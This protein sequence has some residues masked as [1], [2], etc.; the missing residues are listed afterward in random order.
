MH[1]ERWQVGNNQWQV[2]YKLDWF[3]L[4]TAL[5]HFVPDMTMMVFLISSRGYHSNMLDWLLFG[6]IIDHHYGTTC[7]FLFS[8][9]L[10]YMDISFNFP[11]GQKAGRFFSIFST[12]QVTLSAC[13]TFTCSKWDGRWVKA[14]P[15]RSI[16]LHGPPTWGDV[17]WNGLFWIVRGRSL[18]TVRLWK[19]ALDYYP[20]SLFSSAII[21]TH[22]NIRNPHIY[23]AGAWTS[24]E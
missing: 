15:V 13:H 6:S 9:N 18:S 14:S 16:C 10:R 21:A 24:H 8:I 2:G 11:V 12:P 19:T 23:F 17:E 5:F 3:Q 4:L 22:S 1:G 20:S 7:Q